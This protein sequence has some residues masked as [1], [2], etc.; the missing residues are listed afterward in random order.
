MRQGDL[1]ENDRRGEPRVIYR[2]TIRLKNGKVLYA[3]QYGLKAFPIRI[4]CKS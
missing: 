3:W 2:K 1:F 4:R